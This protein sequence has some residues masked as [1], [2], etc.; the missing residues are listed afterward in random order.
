MCSVKRITD[1]IAR[2][3]KDRIET[4]SENW[5]APVITQHCCGRLQR[6]VTLNMTLK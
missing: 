4:F 6:T 2:K 3:L 5:K 1:N